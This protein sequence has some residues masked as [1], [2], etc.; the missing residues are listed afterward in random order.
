LKESVFFAHGAQ[1]TLAVGAGSKETLRTVHGFRHLPVTLVVLAVMS[2]LPGGA[3]LIVGLL[4]RAAAIGVLVTMLAAIVMVHGRYGLF[5][6]WFGD[7]KG[8]GIG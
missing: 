5:I 3:S 2:E 6:N 7:R 1:K 8:H 4:S